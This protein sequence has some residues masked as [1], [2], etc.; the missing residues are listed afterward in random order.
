[1]VK[2]NLVL[3]C[4]HSGRD[5]LSNPALLRNSDNYPPSCKNCEKFENDSDLRTMELSK[6]IADKIAILSGGREVHTQIALIN[7][8]YVD[9]N[10]QIECAV[11]PSLDK[12]AEI[13]YHEYHKGIFRIIKEMDSEIGNGLQFLFDIHGTGRTQ[14][15]DSNGQVHPIDII[16]GTDQGRSI[17]ALSE[18][19]SGIFWGT[20]G[21]ISL[22]KSKNKK[23]WPPNAD[24]EVES[25]ILDGG[26]TI[27]TF[28]ST[29][30]YEK[31]V[32]IQCEIIPE[33]RLDPQKREQFAGVMAECIWNFVE[34][35][36]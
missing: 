20:K 33:H 36:I 15:E 10:R 2:L 18:L 31:L 32:A 11:E 23:V 5:V 22:L 21:L 16:I 19:D 27:K 28:G 8:D 14:V 30:F 24:E 13:K 25:R 3:T 7:R 12:T 6:S 1:M 29:Q 17:H 9:F 35:L 34:P 26:Y 4:P